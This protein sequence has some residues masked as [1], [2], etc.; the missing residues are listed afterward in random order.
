MNDKANI[1][2]RNQPMD[3]D[4]KLTNVKIFKFLKKSNIQ[5]CKE[6]KEESVKVEPVKME[7]VKVEPVEMEQVEVELCSRETRAMKRKRQ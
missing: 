7:S 2:E 6:I 3:L 1:L 4:S 5:L